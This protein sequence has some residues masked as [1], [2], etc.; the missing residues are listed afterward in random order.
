MIAV[1]NQGVSGE[2]IVELLG[3]ANQD[4]DDPDFLSGETDESKIFKAFLEISQIANH[5]YDAFFTKALVLQK[6]C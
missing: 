5:Q 3:S 1:L 2:D 6:F 4:L